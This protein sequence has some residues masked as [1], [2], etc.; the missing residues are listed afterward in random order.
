FR[1]LRKSF[2][3]RLSSRITI[4]VQRFSIKAKLFA[5]SLRCTPADLRT[6]CQA[7]TAEDGLQEKGDDTGGHKRGRPDQVEVEPRLAKK[8]EAELSIDHPS[9]QPR[10]C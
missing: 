4:P 10:D 1:T 8:G 5:L 6:I 2:H 9:D 3:T 7:G